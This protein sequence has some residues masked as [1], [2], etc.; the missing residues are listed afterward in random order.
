MGCYLCEDPCLR[1]DDPDD[2]DAW[3]EACTDCDSR[4]WGDPVYRL[5]E[6]WEGP[7][8]AEERRA[9]SEAAMDRLLTALLVVVVLGLAATAVAAAAGWI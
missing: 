9:A 5:P 7:S 2:A 1:P 8:C 6:F 4:F 3:G